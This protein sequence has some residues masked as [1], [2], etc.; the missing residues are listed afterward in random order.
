MNSFIKKQHFGLMYRV[1][2]AFMAVAF[3][4]TTAVPAGYAQTVTMSPATTMNLPVPGTMVTMSEGFHPALIRGLRIDP[5]NPLKFNFIVETGDTPLQGAALQQEGEKLIKYFLAALTVPEEDMWV[6]LSPYEAGRIISEGL[7]DTEMGRDLL[8][9]DYMLKQ[10]SA[11]LMYPEDELGKKFW[12]RVYNRAQEEFGSTDVPMDTFNKI[13]IVPSKAVVYE[14]EESAS[15]YVVDNHLKV[16]LEDDYFAAQNNSDQWSVISDQEKRQKL[17]T[18]HRSL[19]TEIIRE[20]LIPEIEKEVNE[21]ETFANLRQIFH[22]MILAEWYKQNLRQGLLGQVYVDQNKTK[23]VDTTDKQVNQ[24]IYEQYIASFKKG[25]YDYIKEDYDPATQQI[26]PRKYFSGGFSRDKGMLMRITE[27]GHERN[28][29]A[30]Q[31]TALAGNSNR[32][33]FAVIM[34]EATSEIQ[35]ALA[36]AQGADKRKNAH[37]MD[38]AELVETAKKMMRENYNKIIKSGRVDDAY[39][40]SVSEYILATQR[41]A[42]T[43]N[44]EEIFLQHLEKLGSYLQWNDFKKILDVFVELGIGDVNYRRGW[45][46]EG[47]KVSA[48]AIK[49]WVENWKKLSV[50]QL[51]DIWQEFDPY[52]SQ[53]LGLTPQDKLDLYKSLLK[54]KIFKAKGDLLKTWTKR[55]AELDKLLKSNDSAN[56]EAY[57]RKHEKTD[58][59]FTGAK[60]EIHNIYVTMNKN[61]E[62]KLSNVL[63]SKYFIIE[64]QGKESLFNPHSFKLKFNY[65]R[66]RNDQSDVRLNYAAQ[67][68]VTTLYPQ[69]IAENF[70]FGESEGG[71]DYEI[72]FVLRGSVSDDDI[73]RF[74]LQELQ[75]AEE[76]EEL[77]RAALVIVQGADKRKKSRD[78]DK[79]ELVEIAK[80]MMRNGGDVYYEGRNILKLSGMPLEEIQKIEVEINTA[81]LHKNYRNFS[82]N[83]IQYISFEY[84]QAAQRLG[85]TGRREVINPIYFHVATLGQELQWG[86]FKEILN[87]FVE[88]GINDVG[89]KFKRSTNFVRPALTIQE[90]VSHWK[91]QSSE[92]FDAIWQEFDPY[93]NQVLGLSIQ[94]KYDLYE[95]LLTD[96]KFKNESPQLKIWGK[97]LVGLEKLLSPTSGSIDTKAYQLEYE[98]TDRDFTGTKQEIDNIDT[99]TYKKL[100]E[101][102]TDEISKESFEIKLDSEEDPRNPASFTLHFKHKD[103]GD[104]FEE[105]QLLYAVQK[106]V[107]EMYPQYIME[108]NN[109]EEGEEHLEY[110]IRF[111]RRSTLSSFDINFLIHQET[112]LTEEKQRLDRAV[113]VNNVTNEFLERLETK[114]NAVENE[115]IKEKMKAF[116]KEFY[117]I[118][119]F[120]TS[121]NQLASKLS[122]VKKNEVD[123]IMTRVTG[124]ILKLLTLFDGA[125]GHGLEEFMRPDFLLPIVESIFNSTDWQ[126]DDDPVKIL[127]FRISNLFEALRQG[128]FKDWNEALDQ[129]WK[130]SKQN[131]QQR[132]INKIKAFNLDDNLALLKT[133]GINDLSSE[134]NKL[135]ENN[136]KITKEYVKK[137]QNVIGVGT[138]KEVNQL[139]SKVVGSREETVKLF[140]RIV[141]MMTKAI[142]D[143]KIKKKQQDI[144]KVLLDTSDVNKPTTLLFISKFLEKIEKEQ[145]M[146][147][148]KNIARFIENGHLHT[149]QDPDWGDSAMRAFDAKSV[150]IPDT[151][152]EL[153]GQLNEGTGK[154]YGGINLNAKAFNL[155]IKRNGRGVPLPLEFQPLGEMHVDGFLPIIFN[156][157][158]INLPQLLGLVIP[159][160]ATRDAKDE[161]KDI[162]DYYRE[163]DFVARDPMDARS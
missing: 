140:K 109:K 105:V 43:G 161:A 92:K 14:H 100:K 68:S 35:V 123:A 147:T 154:K 56:D 54:Y 162:P 93:I 42:K 2:S 39:Y 41:L 71:T 16:M 33:D 158:P 67:K 97:R 34:E 151:I 62:E 81:L 44:R 108:D 50:G 101:E 86:A 72:I 111:V 49:K 130:E 4:A 11:S 31:L 126:T 149:T 115:E 155:Q 45:G 125:Y 29:D 48:N 80:Q 95:A 114:I 127:K 132:I 37:D 118:P 70:T 75:L 99:L 94:D 3:L 66:L 27:I 112:K 26:M 153:L 64:D 38:K 113:L 1:L 98:T 150:V 12:D 129:E 87:V 134:M 23:G 90:W 51:N 144:M 82:E 78:M 122:T 5:V 119:A 156:I 22:S 57:R 96:E 61:L 141:T 103:V 163:E 13:W 76:V 88:L 102:L 25:V 83:F 10:L 24:K 69:Y 17:T 9:Q 77:D 107:T 19:T 136:D 142:E 79:A 47:V 89:Q 55:L 104:N 84:V 32:H 59:D 131:I 152:D 146:A 124:E 159:E 74:I 46:R 145:Q 121:L 20:V 143:G 36:A 148:L 116:M 58:K 138:V 63:E 157:T 21:G 7:G 8:A 30:S 18:D 120:S 6:N 133:L 40:K 135:E 85:K 160:P 117:D 137:H 139:L 52:L 106:A 53:A 91:V 28:L 65:R 60:G 128:V 110:I 73:K 15:A